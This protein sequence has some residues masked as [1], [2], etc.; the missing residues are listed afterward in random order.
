MCL[1][2]LI[3]SLTIH[4]NSR[5][6]GALEKNK[7]RKQAQR[8]SVFTRQTYSCLSC[9]AGPAA[10]VYPHFLTVGVQQEIRWRRSSQDCT[11]ISLPVTH[12]VEFERFRWEFSE[13]Q[14]V[15]A[16]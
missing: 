12:S 16:Q 15:S 9:S 8:L 13:G 5:S 2:P 11:S 1:T 7:V 10:L 4:S 3:P 6:A 14:R